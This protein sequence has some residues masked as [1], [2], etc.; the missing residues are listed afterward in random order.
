MVLREPPDSPR[1]WCY[2]CGEANPQGLQIDFRVEGTAAV[3]SFRARTLHQGFPGLVHGGITAAALDE[4]MGWA[5]FAAGIWAVT[6]RMEV[7]YRHPLPL[8]Q[9]LTVKGE[10]T[11][12]R[13]RR[14]E[15]VAQILGAEDQLL[16]EAD[17]VF[18][19]VKEERAREL[20]AF[21]LGRIEGQPAG[22]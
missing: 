10:V 14:V 15:V 8:D 11:R 18:M 9:E 1:R 20:A 4:A 13:G 5:V 2:G 17:A 22:G 16:A 19:R 21:Y 3:G 12:D 7:R 6:A